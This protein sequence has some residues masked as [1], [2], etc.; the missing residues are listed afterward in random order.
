MMLMMKS[1]RILPVSRRASVGGSVLLAFQL[2]APAVAA[3][4]TPVAAPVVAE[5]PGGG[6]GA[7][8]MARKL[9]NPLANIRALMTDN[10]I[11]FNTGNDNGTSFGFQLQP[12][13]AIDLPDQGITLLPRGVIP[14]LG[15]EPGTDTPLTGQPVTGGG[16]SVWGV[17][18]IVLQGFV[19][20]HV[21]SKWKWG[22]G[23]QF[24]LGTATDYRLSGP[25]WG[26]G[27][28]GVV[29]GDI[30]PEISFAG[31]LGNLWSFDGRFNTM[32]IQPMVYYNIPSMPGAYI[33]YNAVIT[34]DWEAPSG[35]AFTL[36]LGLTVGKT[37]D[38]GNG[39]GLDV[40][41]GP[42]Y[43]ALRPDGAADWQIR[44]GIS[45]LFP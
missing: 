9:Q 37:F 36:P 42:Y 25:N 19:A 41:I 26:A 3:D 24:S 5:T 20:P 33:A 14:I 35:D 6:G 40:G 11:G 23:P 13:Y 8:E 21:E 18:D 16:S 44:F 22:V 1:F 10:A 38:M 27:L 12:V 17:G 7:A 43:N 34:I 45:W 28:A 15:L 31:I 32:T 29:T 30:T 2:V 4:E 39:N